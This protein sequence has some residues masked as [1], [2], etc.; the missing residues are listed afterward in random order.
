[1]TLKPFSNYICIFAGKINRAEPIH[2]VVD[3]DF[4]NGD[5]REAP[6]LDLDSVSVWLS[7]DQSNEMLGDQP[8]EIEGNKML[9]GDRFR[10]DF[11]FLPD[12]QHAI[13]SFFDLL[14]MSFPFNLEFFLICFHNRSSVRVF[15]D[16]HHNAEQ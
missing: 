9:P 10:S 8:K 16:D 4:E 2:E 11:V 15:F 7:G 1:M 6:S 13:H 12:N 14:N 3:D 5:H